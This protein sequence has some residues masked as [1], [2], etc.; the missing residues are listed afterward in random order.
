MR[1]LGPVFAEMQ[2]VID[3][4]VAAT[5]GKTLQDYESD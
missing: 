4:I 2:Y 1:R 5:F 3:G